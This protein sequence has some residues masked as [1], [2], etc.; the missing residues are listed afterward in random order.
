MY[1]EQ[2]YVVSSK[3]SLVYM[4]GIVIWLSPWIVFQSE[5]NE[6]F[7][8]MRKRDFLKPMSQQI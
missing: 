5:K 2:V 8:A 4:G 7:V 6:R 1:E 3:F